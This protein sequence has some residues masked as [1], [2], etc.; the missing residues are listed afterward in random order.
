MLI[1]SNLDQVSS[2]ILLLLIELIT[3]LNPF[4]MC[5]S[6]FPFKSGNTK[7]LSRYLPAQV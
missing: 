6:Y 1:I 7:A 2:T 5:L 3:L 4:L